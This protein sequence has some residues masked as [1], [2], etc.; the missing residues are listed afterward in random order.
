MSD[1]SPPSTV[2]ECGWYERLASREAAGR[3]GTVLSFRSLE[4]RTG[5]FGRKASDGSKE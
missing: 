4:L 1:S 3:V 2:S 5:P